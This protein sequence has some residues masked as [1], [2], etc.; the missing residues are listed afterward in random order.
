VV[1]DEFPMLTE[2]IRKAKDP[3][4]ETPLSLDISVLSEAV[5]VLETRRKRSKNPQRW[6]SGSNRS[7]LIHE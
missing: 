5:L 2:T 3:P 6:P 7:F 1:A 4:K